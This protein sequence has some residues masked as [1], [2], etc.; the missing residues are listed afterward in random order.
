MPALE[1]NQQFERYRITQWLGNGVSGESYEAVDTMLQRKVTLKLIHPWLTL[2]DSAH[3]QFFR[4]MQSISTLNHPYLAA[5]LDYGEIDGR[6]YVARRFLSNGS[7]LSNTGRLWF[8]PPLNVD[9]AIQYT[10]QLAQALDYIHNCGYLHGAVT[11][12]NILVLRGPNMNH[13]PGYAPFLL[14]DV[15]LSNFV[16]RFG[17]P[18]IKLL[19]VT[20]APEQIGKRVTP[21]SDQFA[22]AVLLYFWLAGRPPYIGTPEET[23]HAKLTGMF[24][25]LF[26]L[27]P[28]ISFEQE[29][30]LRR[31]LSI[32]PDERYPSVA[33]FA[34]ALVATLTPP[35]NTAPP[36]PSS[37][38]T[39][40]PDL[41]EQ[42]E[43]L[44]EALPQASQAPVNEYASVPQFETRQI[45]ELETETLPV[46]GTPA[47]VENIP[48]VEASPSVEPAIAPRVDPFSADEA[49]PILMPSP[50]QSLTLEQML[51]ALAQPLPGIQLP[52]QASFSVAEEIATVEE[53]PSVT[54]LPAYRENE[55]MEMETQAGQAEQSV[56]VVQITQ[57]IAIPRLQINWLSG[58]ET[59]EYLLD[60]KEIMLGRAGSDD[61]QL[62]KDS[63]IS[64]HH[65]L[66]KY[67]D[68]Q[69]L[70]YDLRSFSGI[71]VNGE[72][73]NNDTG[74]VLADG[75]HINI[76]NCELT[77]RKA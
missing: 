3:R 46:P 37:I 62:D 21:A 26:S 41:K 2:P 4:E 29:E 68:D 10:Y 16:R 74:H 24:P 34:D 45:S 53:A 7:L 36:T 18:Q 6:L 59:R 66:L 9:D 27:N 52:P 44:T 71:S 76:G 50:E 65:A 5:T 49:A 33:A 15:G 60:N 28:D 58:G 23:E 40:Q 47:E 70:I 54:E 73:L 67:E 1:R 30:V 11:L 64:R 20:A 38:K 51:D 75:D 13:E 48:A 25:P 35:M 32:Y 57:P 19:P 61:V 72:K 14:A 63:S 42:L 39:P 12:S 69:Y 56:Q 22:L 55:M 17:Q 8:K 31:A 77:F 43:S